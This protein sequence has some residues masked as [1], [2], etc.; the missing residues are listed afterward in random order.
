M[1]K[2]SEF[3][4]LS[5]IEK[6]FLLFEDGDFLTSITKNDSGVN[7]YAYNEEFIEVYYKPHRNV[8]E[9]I[10]VIPFEKVFEKYSDQI[11]ISDVSVLN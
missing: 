1:K 9:R 5:L 3:I 7:L 8:I 4:K 2:K 11:D 10:E 6:C